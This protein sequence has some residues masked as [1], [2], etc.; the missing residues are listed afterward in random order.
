MEIE[1]Y[2]KFVEEYSI[3][4]SKEEFEEI[5][6]IGNFDTIDNKPAQNLAYCL[7]EIEK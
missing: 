4:I 7:K 3:N 1:E 2:L 6:K 5:M